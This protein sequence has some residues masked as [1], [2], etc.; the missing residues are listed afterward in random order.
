[1]TEFTINSHSYTLESIKAAAPVNWQAGYVEGAKGAGGSVFLWDTDGDFTLANDPDPVAT[2][3]LAAGW[4]A[5]A[6]PRAFEFADEDEILELDSVLPCNAGCV[7]DPSLGRESSVALCMAMKRADT[8]LPIRLALLAELALVY[9]L[10]DDG[11]C[12]YTGG[13]P[14]GAAGKGTV[15]PDA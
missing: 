2:A 12:C 7:P 5:G 4:Y 6:F 8:P 11:L 9:F 3:A 10:N 13:V 1:M 15:C 14:D